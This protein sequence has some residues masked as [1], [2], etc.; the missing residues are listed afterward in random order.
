MKRILIIEDDPMICHELKLLLDDHGYEGIILEDFE[1]ALDSIL[2]IRPD[3][4]LLDIQIPYL[5]GE[6]LLQRLRA[7]SNIPVIMVTSKNTQLDEALSISYGAD[8]YI[9]KPYV[10]NILLLR[11]GAVLK[12]M[13]V[14]TDK[15]FYKDLTFYCRKGILANGKEEII[16][17]KNEMIIFN[18][19]LMHPSCIVSRDELMTE[20]WNNDEFINDNALTVNISRLRRKLK[21]VGYA[22]AICTKKGQGYLLL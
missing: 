5:D 14:S 12:R 16:L 15:I 21:E 19:L 2:K 13:D 6:I 20:L 7:V 22:D 3:L 11:I 18:Y 1:H 10:P 17:T 4:I 9:T 8:D